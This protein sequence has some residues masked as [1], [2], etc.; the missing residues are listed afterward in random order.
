[1][2]PATPFHLPP[3]LRAFQQA[4][5][6]RDWRGLLWIDGPAE[7]SR[8]R[9]QALW[10]GSGW[11]EALWVAPQRPSMVP[12]SQWIP[13]GKARTRLGGEQDLVVFDAVSAEAGFDPD[14]FGALSGTLRSGGLMVLMTPADWGARPDADYGR[15]A[16]HP[17]S[18]AELSCR[19]LARLAGLLAE[20]PD[21]ARWGAGQSPAVPSFSAAARHDATPPP[22][23]TACLTR[24][25]ADAVARL[26]SL[27][28]RRPLVITADRGRG[29]TAALGIACARLLE[30]GVAEVL[31][32]APRAAAVA[33][34][35]E[36]LAALCPQGER[37]GQQF[38][39]GDGRVSFVA[40]DELQARVERGEAGG[41]GRWLLVDEAAAIPAGLLGDWLEVFP[42]IAFA[43]TVHGYEGA[44]R[45]FALRFRERLD[46]QTPAWRECHLAAPVRW[47]PG[48][49]LEALTA[50]LLM[51]DAEP[52]DVRP[53]PLQWRRES[54]QALSRHEPRLRAIFGLLVQAHYRTTPAD[55]RRLLD[56]PDSRVVSLSRDT[57]EPPGVAAVA[58]T[59]DEG[60][61]DAELAE[62]VARGERRPRGHLLAQSLAAHAGEREAL[63]AR[64]RRI[65]RIAVADAC[66]RQGLGGQLLDAEAREARDAGMDL[67]GASFGAEPGL[68]A[69][70]Q[71]RGFRVVRL[72]MTRETATGEHALMMVQPLSATGDALVSR[73]TRRFRRQ[74]PGLL[75]FEL[76][77]LEPQLVL[78]LLAEESTE[79]Q[80]AELS[81]EDR[82]DLEDVAHGQRDPSLV[83]PAMQA[84]VASVAPT[85]QGDHE[86]AILAAWAFQGRGDAWLA[87]RLSLSGA[88]Q[89][90]AWRRATLAAWLP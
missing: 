85:G 81:D 73:L 69:F 54:R 31:V 27:R 42:R 61:F 80:P 23:D 19:Y 66:R 41:A 75:A 32:T 30:R 38:T 84:L 58:I 25:Q 72:G 49:P 67:L 65:V 33:G 76:A 60:G 52:E 46:R 35:F 74:L 8:A 89:V 70:W 83:R 45:G 17:W 86:L 59:S 90:A 22:A 53:G 79:G 11:Q 12:E 10:Q 1:M 77:E 87:R 18:A 7:E 88:R 28:R 68:L 40:P 2:P 55:L 21:I 56:A 24:D 48:D 44:G 29:K 14:A 37:Q 20:A 63:T 26:V 34:L 71:S 13:A 15:L 36:R 4:L 43:T 6:A 50:R 9:G 16:E 64:L 3:L 47:A 82:R 5:E 62:R 51:L 39:L 78:A 57:T